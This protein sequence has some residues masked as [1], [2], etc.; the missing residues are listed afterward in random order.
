[1]LAKDIL[2]AIA[3]NKAE[4]SYTYIKAMIENT[5]AKIISI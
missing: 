4:L 2:R 1:M 5:T 3:D